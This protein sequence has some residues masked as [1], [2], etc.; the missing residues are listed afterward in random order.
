L[1]LAV[2]AIDNRKITQQTVDGWTDIL[3]H[4]PLDIALEAHRMARKNEAVG[5]LEPK[6]IISFAKE[7]AYALDRAKPKVEE[8]PPARF[9]MQK[10]SAHGIGILSCDPCADRIYRF[11]QEHGFDRVHEWAKAEIYG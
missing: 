8:K 6:H 9:P 2:S 4:I 3:R 7:A 5:Y 1:L 11:T 10:C